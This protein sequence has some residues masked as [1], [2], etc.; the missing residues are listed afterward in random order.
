[1]RFALR[2]RV[3]GLSPE[4]IDREIDEEREKAQ[5]LVGELSETIEHLAELGKEIR[6]GDN[7]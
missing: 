7:E 6:K 3:E 2:R 1:M 5:A 4:D